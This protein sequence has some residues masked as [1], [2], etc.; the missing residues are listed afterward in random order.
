MHWS[1][2]LP[3]DSICMTL[4]INDPGDSLMHGEESPE[5]SVLD[6]PGTCRMLEAINS[7]DVVTG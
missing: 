4:K 2:Q 5:D 7:E 1:W 3:A 6:Y